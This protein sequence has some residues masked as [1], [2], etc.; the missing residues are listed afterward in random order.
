MNLNNVL[1]QFSAEAQKF[2]VHFSHCY[3][4]LLAALIEYYVPW[5]LVN[6]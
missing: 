2:S 4:L 1:I 5:L 6:F 3:L